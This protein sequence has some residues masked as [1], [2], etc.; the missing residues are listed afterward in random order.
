MIT[1][2]RLGYRV[3]KFLIIYNIGSS[4]YF[5][6]RLLHAYRQ[7]NKIHIS[8]K[9]VRVN[10]SIIV[11]H[12]TRIKQH[13]RKGCIWI[14]FLKILCLQCIIDNIKYMHYLHMYQ[15]SRREKVSEKT[16]HHKFKFFR[17]RHHF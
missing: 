3:S 8:E 16:I 14:V 13:F 17:V 11:Y 7:V 1:K 12:L 6:Y 5:V 4:A 10:Y 2:N 15:L 9:I